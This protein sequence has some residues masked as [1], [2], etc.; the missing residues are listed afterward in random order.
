[1]LPAPPPTAEQKTSLVMLVF[2]V[3]AFASRVLFRST[4]PLN[5]ENATVTLPLFTII[6]SWEDWPRKELLRISRVLPFSLTIAPLSL[7]LSLAKLL[8]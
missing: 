7:V 2:F 5:V 6:P 3:R 8:A 4:A 1:M